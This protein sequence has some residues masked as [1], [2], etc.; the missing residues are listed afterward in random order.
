MDC[1]CVLC[2]QCYATL[3]TELLYSH[4]GSQS[5]QSY[6]CYICNSP[7]EFENENLSSLSQSHKLYVVAN[8]Y[9][10]NMYA[11]FKQE[12]TVK[13]IDSSAELDNRVKELATTLLMERKKNEFCLELL[14]SLKKS[15][16]IQITDI[17]PTFYFQD[18]FRILTAI[19]NEPPPTKKTQPLSNPVFDSAKKNDRKTLAVQELAET[20]RIQKQEH[21]KNIFFPSI[22]MDKVFS[23]SAFKNKQEHP[24]LDN[25]D[26]KE[27]KIIPEEKMVHNHHFDTPIPVVATLKNPNVQAKLPQ[28]NVIDSQMNSDNYIIRPADDSRKRMMVTPKGAF[29]E[30][31]KSDFGV[32]SRIDE[33]EQQFDTSKDSMFDHHPEDLVSNHG[34][35]SHNLA[36]KFHKH[37]E[38]GHLGAAKFNR[39]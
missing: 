20:E 35:Q 28:Q 26:D 4:S 22:K 11:K 21:Q 1:F 13:Q 17:S 3:G 37:A 36:R 38:H 24:S 39:L 29:I 19:F 15:F 25:N 9:L 34:V 6:V 27:N 30:K 16:K 8:R 18:K 2:K 33:T 14:I 31:L 12:L 23:F 7:T 32:I 5:S 10:A